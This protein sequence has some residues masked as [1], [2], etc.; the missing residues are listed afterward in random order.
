MVAPSFPRWRDRALLAISLPVVGQLIEKHYG[1]TRDAAERA[2]AAIVDGFA[3]ISARL[4]AQPYLG[5]ARFGA[6][7]L[8]FAALG[9]IMI[10]PPELRFMRHDVPLPAHMRAFIDRLRATPAGA[11]AMRCYREHR[12]P[13]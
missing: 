5:G 1:A 6:A 7:D 8:T 9:G 2:E 10:M 3:R 13:A 11:H 4:E 12:Q